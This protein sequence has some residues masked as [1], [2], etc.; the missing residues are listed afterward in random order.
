MWIL[1]R[2]HYKMLFA[3]FAKSRNNKFVG[4]VEDQIDRRNSIIATV[5][6]RSWQNLSEQ[7]TA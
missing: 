3:T 4:K 5:N 6:L 2:L 1:Q 7:L